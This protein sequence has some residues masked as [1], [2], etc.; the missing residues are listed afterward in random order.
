MGN[1]TKMNEFEPLVMLKVTEFTTVVASS[2]LTVIF[3]AERYPVV[4]FSVPFSERMVTFGAVLS[5]VM[6]MIELL[7]TVESLTLCAV[8]LMLYLP[9][10][11]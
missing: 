3:T 7:V 8:M 9:S 5:M 10:G 4:K 1:P 6:L 11:I 2:D